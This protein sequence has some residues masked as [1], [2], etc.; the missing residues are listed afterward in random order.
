[1]GGDA[2]GPRPISNGETIVWIKTTRNIF[3]HGIAI[4]AGTVVDIPE[5]DAM[6]LLSIRK[7]VK[8]DAPAKAKPVPEPEPETVPEPDRRRTR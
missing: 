6:M 5:T 3:N 8:A 4:E 2:C 7:A 1:M